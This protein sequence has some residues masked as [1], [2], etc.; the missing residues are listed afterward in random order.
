VNGTSQRNLD[1][2]IFEPEL[3][4]NLTIIIQGLV[5]LAV[6]ADVLVVAM[7]RRGRRLLGSSP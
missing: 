5:V 7:L 1:P 4:F 6:S 3:A 2:S